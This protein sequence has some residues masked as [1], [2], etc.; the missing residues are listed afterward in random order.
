MHCLKIRG[1]L[2][3]L[4]ILLALTATA[5]VG[6]SGVDVSSFAKPAAQSAGASAPTITGTPATTA[7]VGSVYTFQP[8]A[9]AT[10][11]DALTFT[12]E[13]L[14]AW[15]T[16]DASS[17]KLTGTPAISDVGMSA[18][19]TIGVTDGNLS[20][21]LPAF[22]IAVDA[23]ASVPPA[24]VIS[25][26]APTS[27][28][29]GAHYLFQPSVSG[30]AGVT[31]TFT[32]TNIPSWAT[33]ST[34]TGQLSGTPSSGAVGNYPDIT[35]SVSDGQATAALPP[36]AIAVTAPPG[37][38]APQPPT[39]SGTPAT[40]VQAGQSYSF[41]PTARDPA[42]NALTF[43]IQNRPAWASFSA[44]TGQLTGTPSNSAVGTY[45]NITISV[46]DGTSSASLPAFAIQVNPAPSTPPQ[47]PTISGSPSTQVQAGQS[48]S[49]TPTARDPAGNTLTFSILNKPSWAAFSST[50]G[51]LSGT[52]ATSAVGSYANITISVSDGQTS[53]SLPA[54]AITVTAPPNQPPTIS[55]T[56]ATL[57]QAGQSYSFTPTAAGSAGATLSFSIQNKPSWANFS[58]ATG[59]LSGT[60]ASANVGTYANIIISV[61]DGTTS[62]SLPPFAIT[63]ASAPAT[64]NVNLAWDAP[65]LNTDGSALT[66][67]QGYVISYGTSAANLNQ[68]VTVASASATSF[69]VQNLAAGTWY[70]AIAAYAGDGT[71]SV[72]SNEVS[73]TVQ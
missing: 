54:F 29:A 72:L 36:F 10:D 7:V 37:N 68:T 71:T 48:Y 16:F 14:P 43:S 40:Q 59:Q 32:A 22:E 18:P 39:I 63:V 30:P 61:S 38:P 41:T 67:L 42:G 35:I 55:G 69:T 51:Q 57:V 47:P 27:V 52:P 5:L 33:F 21:A 60:P 62:A 64:A 26:T 3:P 70:F 49:F 11:G 6:C 46:S 31:L 9:S 1:A 34:D 56:P 13:N 53:A 8:S 4:G 65:T 17:G 15:A 19:I 12:I 23:A 24:L 2:G 73:T 20:A 58:I 44:T 28:Q 45:S 50:T 25:G 66:D